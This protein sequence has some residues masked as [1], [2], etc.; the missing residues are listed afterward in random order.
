MNIYY[1]KM[2]KLNNRRLPVIS[3]MRAILTSFAQLPPVFTAFLFS[4][5]T[6]AIGR[7]Q[8]WKGTGSAARTSELLLQ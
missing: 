2:N 8:D 5:C 7:D 3:R 6:L 4:I 1:S